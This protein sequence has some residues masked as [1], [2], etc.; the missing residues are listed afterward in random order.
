MQKESDHRAY[1]VGVARPTLGQSGQEAKSRRLGNQH[2]NEGAGTGLRVVGTQPPE[3][4]LPIK[5]GDEES[6]QAP[7]ASGDQGGGQILMAEGFADHQAEQALGDWAA[8]GG[9]EGMGDGGKHLLG[10]QIDHRFGGRDRAQ[11]R[12]LFAQHGLEQGFL[13]GEIPVD[14]G[15][16]LEPGSP[17]DT[18]DRGPAEALSR[19]L[20]EG[21]GENQRSAT[22]LI[23]RIGPIRL[24]RPIIAHETRPL[25]KQSI[26]YTI[27]RLDSFGQGVEECTRG[28]HD[29]WGVFG[30]HRAT[31]RSR[32]VLVWPSFSYPRG[33]SEAW[34]APLQSGTLTLQDERNVHARLL[35]CD[36][37]APSDLAMAY[38]EPL[39]AW[40][41]AL[42]PRL[43]PHECATAAED[44]I[45][46]VIKN[47]QSYKPERQQR[48]SLLGYLR[49]SAKA[50]LSNLLRT[51]RRHSARRADLDA[52]ALSPVMGKYL[53][54]EDADP[55]RIVERR[56]EEFAAPAPPPLPDSLRATLSPVEIE[57][58]RLMDVKERRTIVFARLLEIADR[59]VAEQRREVKR[60]KDRLH[61]RRLRAR[62]NHD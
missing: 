44:A 22:G 18:F 6:Q 38:F 53:G 29:L 10:R 49:M 62:N 24:I 27:L 58:L 56:E 26:K 51:E 17:R 37:V 25:I 59:P 8:G 14:E 41:E 9:Q 34:M 11:N 13:G 16:G 45:M 39:T 5:V 20:L 28:N 1:M 31:I 42:Y 30:W 60:A 33:Y 19:E 21:G 3:R 46:A 12:R 43:H 35:A 15:R 54:D 7:W 52:V 40:L 55:A 36:P 61:K 47:P 4:D 50:R 57:M 48:E 32:L 23:S 2:P